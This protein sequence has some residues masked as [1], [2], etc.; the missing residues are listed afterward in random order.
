MKKHFFCHTLVLIVVVLSLYSWK[1]Q[2]QTVALVAE[3]IIT[4]N[5]INKLPKNLMAIEHI[6]SMKASAKKKKKKNKGIR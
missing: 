2:Q 1:Y 5:L 6:D 4:R 3:P